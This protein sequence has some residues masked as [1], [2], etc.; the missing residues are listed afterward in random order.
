M[1]E[2]RRGGDQ[3]GVASEQACRDDDSAIFRR[4][5]HLDGRRRFFVAGI[6]GREGAPPAV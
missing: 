6:A 1:R 2:A 4:D 5:Q 3:R